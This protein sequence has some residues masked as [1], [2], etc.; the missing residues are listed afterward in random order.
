M[1]IVFVS[2]KPAELF[3]WFTWMHNA[4]DACGASHSVRT[5]EQFLV[6]Q[7]KNYTQEST[8]LKGHCPFFC[9][10]LS[11]LLRFKGGQA[12]VRKAAIL[13]S[14]LFVKHCLT[15]SQSNESTSSPDGNVA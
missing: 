9:N 7:D 8:F 3:A 2:L 11:C 6:V 12:W 14:F 5:Q 15:R 1:Q 10:P 4:T 13:S